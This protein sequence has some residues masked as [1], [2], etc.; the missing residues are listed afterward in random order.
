VTLQNL[1]DKIPDRTET[2][3]VS[4]QP[5]PLWDNRS[6]VILAVTLLGIEWFF[7]KRLRMI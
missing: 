5:V 7:R 2:L 6:T 1:P 4:G 3:V